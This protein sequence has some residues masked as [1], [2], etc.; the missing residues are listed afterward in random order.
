MREVSLGKGRFS[1]VELSG[2]CA[3]SLLQELSGTFEI[4]QP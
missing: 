3:L 4:I 1:R 2:S